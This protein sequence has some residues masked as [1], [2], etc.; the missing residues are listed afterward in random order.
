MRVTLKEGIRPFAASL[1]LFQ[2][3][4]T[5]WPFAEGLENFHFC[6]ARTIS[7]LNASG[8]ATSSE[9]LRL[10]SDSVVVIWCWHDQVCDDFGQV[11]GRRLIGMRPWGVN[12]W[13]ST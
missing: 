3:H 9:A 1:H 10:N 5:A 6:A 8:A 2:G 7:T 12:P 13:I 11:L 4:A